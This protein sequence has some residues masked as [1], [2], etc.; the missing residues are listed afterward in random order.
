M[1]MEYEIFFYLDQ[2]KAFHNDA[3]PLTT[4]TTL[5]ATWF[6]TFLVWGLGVIL[7][8]FSSVASGVAKQ[9]TFKTVVENRIVTNPLVEILDI[10]WLTDSQSA[11]RSPSSSPSDDEEETRHPSSSPASSKHHSSG[12]NSNG[13]VLYLLISQLT[14][15]WK[16]VSTF[17]LPSS[18]ILGSRRV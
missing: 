14:S 7:V 16:N 17:H 3:T 15:K 11:L 13:P 6:S 5:L 2:G 12:W 1:C 4:L 10:V 18:Q 9:P 8:V